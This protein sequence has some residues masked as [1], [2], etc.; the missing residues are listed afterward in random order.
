[1]GWSFCLAGQ[2]SRITLCNSFIT[3]SSA[4]ARRWVFSNNSTRQCY[5]SFSKIVYLS[6][7]FENSPTAAMSSSKFSDN[8]AELFIYARLSISAMITSVPENLFILLQTKQHCL[9]STG[10]V[11]QRLIK[12]WSEGF[13]VGFHRNVV[14]TVD[15]RTYGTFLKQKR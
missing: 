2:P 5:L 3:E 6:W 14:I 11:V 9:I 8:G 4:D 12:D 1:M 13:V 15:I 7:Y 10:G